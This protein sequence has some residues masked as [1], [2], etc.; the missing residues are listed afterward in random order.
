MT[1]VR[2]SFSLAGLG[3]ALLLAGCGDPALQRGVAPPLTLNQARAEV[4]LFRFGA[5]RLL[6]ERVSEMAADGAVRQ[7]DAS[8]QTANIPQRDATRALLIQMGLDPARISW[9]ATPLDRIVLTRTDVVTLPCAAALRPDWIGDVGQSVTSLGTCVQ[10]NNLADMVSDPRDLAAPVRLQPS[11]GAVSAR[12][13]RRWEEGTVKQPPK[14]SPAGEY[15]G[16]GGAPDAGPA[17]APPPAAVPAQSSGAAAG[18]PL[19]SNAPLTGA[20]GSSA[21]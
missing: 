6:R 19:L 11:N 12:A 9:T 1:A 17:A 16:G 2:R 14:T 7:L 10:A 5:G 18:N 3:A 8:I 13:V 4:P 20:A 21:E 15:G